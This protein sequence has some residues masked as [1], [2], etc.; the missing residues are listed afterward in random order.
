MFSEQCQIPFDNVTF[1]NNK[2]EVSGGAIHL[3]SSTVDIHNCKA[4]FNFAGDKGS[5]A[6]ISS[7]SKLKTNFLTINH[8]NSNLISVT[9]GSEAEMNHVNLPDGNSY[10]PITATVKSHIYLVNIYSRD[11]EIL[12]NS[13]NRRNV[14]CVDTSSSIEGTPTGMYSF[15]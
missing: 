6:L 2:A 11:A 3:E 5:F 13:Q 8:I 14:V 10:C 9:D 12:K 15:F 1:D 4:K 7:N